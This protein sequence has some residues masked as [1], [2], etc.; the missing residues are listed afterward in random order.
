MYIYN[1][2]QQM[3]KSYIAP[4][5]I[6]DNKLA[7]LMSTGKA[8]MNDQGSKEVLLHFA[9]RKDMNR[10]A[11]NIIEG[12]GFKLHAHKH[13]VDMKDHTGGSILGSIGHVLGSKA[14]RNVAGTAAQ[15]GLMTVGAATGNPIT[16][17]V[18]GQVAKSAITGNGFTSVL[19]KIAT[20]KPA[21][22]LMVSG[23]KTV[24]QQ[25]GQALGNYMT[26]TSSGTGL[27][28]GK[29]AHMVH[30][31]ESSGAVPSDPGYGLGGSRN[32][33]NPSTQSLDVYERMAKVRSHRK[34]KV[35]GS[36]VPL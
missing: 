35:G 1:K 24:G 2:T 21:Q 10:Y 4:G 13:L 18:A 29:V 31:I 17:I 12:K 7:Q 26:G 22:Q 5:L 3:P 28:K 9:K 15:S 25:A 11:R 27:R 19:G 34:S 30:R 32:I 33:K 23:A 8:M 14:V 6:D 36:M 20:S 16:G